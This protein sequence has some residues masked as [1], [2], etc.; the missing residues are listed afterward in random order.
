MMLKHFSY[1][2]ILYTQ[3]STHIIIY[4]NNIITK[5]NA[6]NQYLTPTYIIIYNK[7]LCLQLQT[8]TR[9]NIFKNK[10]KC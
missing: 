2:F 5:N 3:I 6:N 7:K 1:I 10:L 8:L 9:N 4:I